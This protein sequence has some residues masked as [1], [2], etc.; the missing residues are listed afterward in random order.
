MILTEA[1]ESLRKLEKQENVTAPHVVHPHY[2]DVCTRT[3]GY[4]LTITPVLPA[5]TPT[6]PVPTPHYRYGSCTTSAPRTIRYVRLKFVK[7]HNFIKF[8]LRKHAE[9]KKRPDFMKNCPRGRLAEARGS[10]GKTAET[11]KS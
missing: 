8:L 9:A 7:I 2:Q 10:L 1:Y 3:P 11:N 6:L 5:P 4:P